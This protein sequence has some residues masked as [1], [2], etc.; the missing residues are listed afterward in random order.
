MIMFE[1]SEEHSVLKSLMPYV[2]GILF[3]LGICAVLLVL[4]GVNPLQ[5]Y[6]S[7]LYGAFGNTYNISETMVKTAPLLL[8][9]LAFLIGFKANFWNIGGEGQFYIG[10]LVGTLLAFILGGDLGLPLVIS[11][12]VILVVS[13][14]A[15]MA[16]LAIPVLLKVKIG[17]NE[18]FT[19]IMFNFIA[20]HFVQHLLLGPI[21]DPA[22][23]NPQTPMLPSNTWLPRLFPFTRF[24][25]G[26]ILS[27]LI[28]LVAY[29]L[30]SK[31][32][33]GYK[34][35]AT[36]ISQ[37]AATFGGIRVSKVQGIAALLGAGMAGIAGM[38]ETL[39][40]THLLIYGISPGYGFSGII[41]AV[42]GRFS[43]VKTIFAAIF[44]AALLNGAETM[45]RGAGV[46]FGMVYI[47]QALIVLAIVG[48]EMYLRERTKWFGT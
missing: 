13:F 42:L 24:H 12:P 43:P 5:A 26:I 15:G 9:A 36:G 40:T 38:S 48:I 8:C 6:W 28:A 30:V 17:V 33:I 45:Q 41:V 31:T 4:I 32:L 44:F 20:I 22:S 18:I 7:L 10:A 35:R 11:F 23:N 1:L 46:P 39:G 37:E 16:W 3:A 34:I 19:T 14:L 29:V 21:K 27:I 47:L 2:M 25:I